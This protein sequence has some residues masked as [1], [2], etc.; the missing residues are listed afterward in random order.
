MAPL[1]LPELEDMQQSCLSIASKCLQPGKTGCGSAFLHVCSLLLLSGAGDSQGLTR[2]HTRGAPFMA[3]HACSLC[4]KNR[5]LSQLH[6]QLRLLQ[7]N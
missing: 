4:N 1:L 6:I 2:L 5:R 7:A 3:G